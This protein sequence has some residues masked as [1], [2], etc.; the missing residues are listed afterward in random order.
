MNIFTNIENKQPTG[1]IYLDF[2]KAFD[3]VSHNKLLCKVWKIGELLAISG[4]G[5]SHT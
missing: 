1:I 2:Q 5:L 4:S 3:S